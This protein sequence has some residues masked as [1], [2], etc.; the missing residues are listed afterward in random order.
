MGRYAFSELDSIGLNFDLLPIL[1]SGANEGAASRPWLD[2]F[3]FCACLSRLI[4][5]SQ[6]SFQ[7]THQFLSSFLDT[8]YDYG[9]HYTR[10]SNWKP[11]Q[12]AILRLPAELCNAFYEAN[13]LPLKKPSSFS[14]NWF[15]YVARC[16]LKLRLTDVKSAMATR[17]HDQSDPNG[18][19]S[20]KVKEGQSVHVKLTRTL[21]LPAL[22]TEIEMLTIDNGILLD[23]LCPAIL[24][25]KDIVEL[26]LDSNQFKEV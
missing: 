12:R 3:F 22:S 2:L 20:D 24:A 16:H 25:A 1:F 13:K 19:Q 8:V 26:T 6:L 7:Y 21:Q 11:F 15:H 14:F 4:E 9:L 17:A 23:T 18:D 10:G 5:S